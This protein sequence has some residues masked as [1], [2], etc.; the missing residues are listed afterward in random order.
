MGLLHIG[1]CLFPTWL[2]VYEK[3]YIMYYGHF[4]KSTASKW[5][6][7]PFLKLSQILKL[8]DENYDDDGDQHQRYHKISTI[9]FREKA[10]LTFIPKY[11]TTMEITP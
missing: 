4:S 11:K 9:S 1:R 6:R 5:K 10:G 8:F 7:S 3:R 2:K